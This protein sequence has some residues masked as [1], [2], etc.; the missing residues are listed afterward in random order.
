MDKP[1]KRLD[2]TAKQAVSYCIP[3][4]LRDEQIKLAIERV[5]GRISPVHELRS[6]PCAL[7]CYG[8]SLNDTWEQIKEFKYVFTCSGAHKFLVERGIVPTWHVEVDPRQHKVD[9][10]GPPHHDVEYI[11]ASTC[12][13]KVFDHLDGFNVKLWHVYDPQEEGMLRLPHGEWALTGGC[14]VGLRLMTLAR[15]FGFTEHHIFGMDGN[16]G[17]SGKHAAAHP[18]QAKDYAIVEYPPGSGTEWQTTS[19]FLEAARGTFHELNQMPDVKATFYGDG[20][21]QAMAKDYVPKYVGQG[22]AMI[23]FVKPELIST[24]YRSLNSQLHRENLA[25][26]VGGGKHA[27]R[28]LK[29]AESI[30]TTSILDYGCGK[31]YLAKAIPFPIWEYDPAVQGKQDSPR[32][33]D[34]VVC[35]DVLE[36]IEPEKLAYVLHDL[37][38]CVKQVGY[39]TIH[40]QAAKKTLPDGRNTHLIQHGEDWWRKRL[41]RYFTIGKILKSGPELIVVVGPRAVSKRSV[42]VSAEC[43]HA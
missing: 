14:S 19:S 8:P 32:P 12:H 18:S 15:F 34:L 37:A 40:T 1:I 17:K 21:V 41:D 3:T 7:V 36:H 25:Y 16:Q 20:L 24:E 10:I 4:F 11:I 27:E 31:G 28:V 42:Y 6:E 13:P 23:G 26:G 2:A 43:I 38:R 22:K 30:K 9:L 33:A 5:K 39:F 29:L 35:T